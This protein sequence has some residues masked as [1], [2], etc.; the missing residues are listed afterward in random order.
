M[1]S[2]STGVVDTDKAS[3]AA[4]I[5]ANFLKKFETVLKDTLG[6]GGNW[7]L[8]KTRSKKSRDTGG[9]GFI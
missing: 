8:K 3:W 5:S 6:L 7:S 9:G 2:I 1:F 4:N